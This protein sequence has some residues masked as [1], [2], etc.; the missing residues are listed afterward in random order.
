MKLKDTLSTIDKNT[1][2]RIFTGCT[3]LFF[4]RMAKVPE[5]KWN[6]RV[7]PYMNCDVLHQSIVN[8]IIVLVI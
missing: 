6:L 5:R 8:G 7:L 1:P 4:G 2:I 3:T